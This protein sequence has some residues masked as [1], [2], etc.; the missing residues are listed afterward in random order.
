MLLQSSPPGGD[1]AGTDLAHLRDP[2]LM[3][4][5]WQDV[6]LL[7]R[8]VRGLGPV[9]VH[10]EP[11]LWGYLEQADAVS[12]ARSFARRWVRLRDELAPHVVL[13]YH[14]STWGTK[15]D[16]AG[17]H[18]SDAAVRAYATQAAAFYRSLDTR[19]D[20]AF[21][22]FSDRDADF[23]K[24]VEGNPNTWFTPADFRRELLFGKTFMQLAGV[25]LAVWQIPLG[26]TYLDDTWDHFR[27]N[28]VQWFL[29]PDGRSHLQAYVDAGYIGFLFGGGADG[30]TSAQTDGGYFFAHAAAYY[31]RGPI[32]LR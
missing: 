21:E 14:L 13:A 27:D 30:T 6:R 10:V 29:G 31:R 2:Q 22:D 5:Y 3:D 4:A 20:V 11:D 1:E 7:L 12:L 26:N 23:Y 17:E 24:I 28:R 8:R 25:R 18:S 32:P 16:I 9:I 19:F 15:H